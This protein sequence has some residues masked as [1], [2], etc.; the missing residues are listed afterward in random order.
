MK[1]HPISQAVFG[2][3]RVALEVCQLNPLY[4]NTADVTK[5]IASTAADYQELG[6]AA[7]EC[8]D[9]VSYNSAAREVFE[10]GRVNDRL[11]SMMEVIIQILDFISKQYSK[12]RHS[13]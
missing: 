11:R 1:V 9:E 2:I 7:K 8:K 3:A 5:A 4:I 10:T 13:E 12:Q 6:T